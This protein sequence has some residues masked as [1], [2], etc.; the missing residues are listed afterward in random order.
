MIGVEMFLD[1]FMISLMRGT[2]SVTFMDATPA[3]WK[4]FSVIWVPGS[5]M[6][7]APTAPTALPGS[8]RLDRYLVTQRS[9]NS[10]SWGFVT[11]TP[12][13]S[14]SPTRTRLA[15]AKLTRSRLNLTLM[16]SLILC[17]PSSLFSA[18]A[19]A[20]ISGFAMTFAGVFRGLFCADCGTNFVPFFPPPLA[21]AGLSSSSS[22]ARPLVC[23][24]GDPIAVAAAATAA[25]EREPLAEVRVARD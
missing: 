7:C 3:K 12:W 22:E 10:S 18:V 15:R 1:A 16:P 8:I 25:P 5:P 14:G 20:F 2:P 13:P 9:K 11:P 4:V 24:L 21:A 23:T 17:A 6:D 19:I